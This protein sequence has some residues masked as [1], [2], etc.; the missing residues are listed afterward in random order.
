[1]AYKFGSSTASDIYADGMEALDLISAMPGENSNQL[2]KKIQRHLSCPKY[3]SF[4]SKKGG[5]EF[6][7]C[8]D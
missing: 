5:R 3:V 2:D 7:C 1:M 8:P 4:C 6:S